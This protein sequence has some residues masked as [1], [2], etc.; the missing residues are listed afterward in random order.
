MARFSKAEVEVE[1]IVLAQAV[2]FYKQR[3]TAEQW[4]K[5]GKYALEQ[6]KFA[7]SL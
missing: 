6:F 5:E 1:V 3:G 4:I 7:C 2:V